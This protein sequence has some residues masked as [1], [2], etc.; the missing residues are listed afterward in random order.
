M[1][2]CRTCAD[3]YLST[4]E[5]TCIHLTGAAAAAILDHDP[6]RTGGT[7]GLGLADA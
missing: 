7:A 1:R 6:L 2:N 3:A 4:Y 5:Y